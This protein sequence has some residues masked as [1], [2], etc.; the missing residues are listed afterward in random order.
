MKLIVNLY[1]LTNSY[2]EGGT[3]NGHISTF[4]TN[5]PLW[6]RFTRW[7]FSY[8]NPKIQIQK[9]E[10]GMSLKMKQKNSLTI[11]QHNVNPPVPPGQSNQ[12]PTLAK[13]P[14]SVASSK[15]HGFF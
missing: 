3:L 9:L 15:A 1:I 14:Q 2:P 13:V 10:I 12:I 8:T 11:V 5:K 7:M 6:V 4:A